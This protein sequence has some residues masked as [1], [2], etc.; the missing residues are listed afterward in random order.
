MRNR[1]IVAVVTA[2]SL[3]GSLTI[4]CRGAD[5]RD[6]SPAPSPTLSTSETPPE[7]SP[8]DLF[9]EWMRFEPPNVRDNSGFRKFYVDV[10]LGHQ[11]FRV[12]PRG[13]PS[14]IARG[15]LLDDD[16]LLFPSGQRVWNRKLDHQVGLAGEFCFIHST[17]CLRR[18]A[19]VAFTVDGSPVVIYDNQYAIT[20]FPSHTTFDYQLGPVAIAENKY[21]TYDDRV[22]VSYDARSLD[23]KPHSLV[24]DAAVPYPR[25]PMG[26]TVAPSFPMLG[27]GNYQGNPLYLYLDANSF[28]R[29]PGNPI[30]LSR[31]LSLPADGGT[32]SASLALRFALE[33]RATPA[34]PLPSMIEHASTYNRWFA[35]NIPYFDCSDASFKKMWYYRWWIVRFHL[36][37]LRDAPTPDL[38]DF[39]FYEGKLG[40][41]NPIVFAIPAQLKELTYLRDPA[42]AFSQLRNSYRNRASNGAT[43]DPPGSPYW[44]ETY[45]HWTVQ[46]AAELHR[47]HPIPHDLLVELLP[48]MAEDVRAW[49][50][51]YDADGD[52]LPERS[53][54]RVTGY[55]LDIL[56]W[57]YWV[58]TKLDQRA[59]PPAM[60]RVD[61]ASFVYG[62]ATG[63]AEL[64]TAVG[65]EDLAEEFGERAG[66]IRAAAIEHLW[67]DE[68]AFFYPQRAED[69]ARAPIRELHGLFA[70]TTG[71]APD[72]ERFTR[73]LRYLVDP[74]EFWSRYPPVIT[75]QAHYRN[76]TWEMD[77]LTRNIAPHPISM[78]G[79]TLIQAIR[80]YDQS[81]VKPAHVMELLRR[82]NNLVYPGV[83]PNDPTWRPNAHEYYSQ[84]EPF[85]REPN[86]KPSDISHDFHSMWLSLVVEGPIGLVPRSDDVLEVDPMAKGWD[87]FLVDGL[88][89]R[90]RDV[91]IAWD[92]PG[93]GA[94][95]YEGFPEGLSV[96]LDGTQVAH[97]PNLGRLLVDL[98][99]SRALDPQPRG[100]NGP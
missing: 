21:I 73:A 1:S 29:S 16:D 34:T 75:S 8:P 54:P 56:S 76:W 74:E 38:H 94:P 65:D 83:H 50:T 9:S 98:E 2:V 59:R 63:L 44:G 72:Q 58:G 25:L 62:N 53:R 20:R 15:L 43:V 100:G 89:Y 18:V 81:A 3:A 14:Y 36:V 69:D 86:P 92:R 32:R 42:Y 51:A 77:G 88:R 31:T 28:E 26:G 30:R 39:A 68:T 70:F 66:R 45:S 10:M 91:T 11:I 5:E 12:P 37:D 6:Q 82:Y 40:F 22:A 64:A 90:G 60:E 80:R 95:R 27:A 57:W 55:D 61:F 33:E 23:G 79:R 19:D 7:A 35:E 24:I 17:Y 49:M 96:R 97:R 67:D 46:A 99:R 84:W 93:D 71:L 78:G 47:V 48:R 85:A 4:G 13:V 41:D 87:Y 52:A